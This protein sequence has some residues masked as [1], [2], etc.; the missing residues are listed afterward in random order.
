[1]R[2]QEIGIRMALGAVPSDIRRAV[3]GEAFV[4]AGI[5][6]A[7][8]LAAAFALSRLMSTLLFETSASDP[9][10]FATTAVVLALSALVSAWLP[11]RRAMRVDP[12]IAMRVE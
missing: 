10:T 9:W 4:L 2:T 8:G 12:M 1:M 11:A 7:L 3:L 6:T 5:G